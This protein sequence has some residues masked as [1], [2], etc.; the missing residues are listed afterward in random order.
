MLCPPIIKPIIMEEN[1]IKTEIELIK[2]NCST[3]SAR[4]VNAIEKIEKKIDTIIEA[5]HKQDLRLQKLESDKS[6]VV[7]IITA[8]GA[9]IFTFF[10]FINK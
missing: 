2:Q 9:L 1:E 7:A 5:D 10:R 8:I 3:C 6:G 4:I